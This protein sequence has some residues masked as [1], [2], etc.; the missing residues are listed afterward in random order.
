MAARKKAAR[1]ARRPA[2]RKRY[3]M[4]AAVRDALKRSRL[5]SAYR[6]RPPYQRNDYLMWIRKAVRP[7]TRARRIEQMLGELRRGNVYM[8]MKWRA[9]L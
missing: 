9:T 7:A 8:K 1:S 4:P 2:R 6:A 3:A 5:E